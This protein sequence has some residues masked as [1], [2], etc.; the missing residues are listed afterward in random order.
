MEKLTKRQLEAA[1]ILHGALSGD[2]KDTER[3][4]E[5][6]STSDL[7]VQLTPALQRIAL[8]NY[9]EQPKQWGKYATRVIHDDFRV[10]EYN[11]FQF[12]QE[13]IEPNNAG[14][15][16][17]EG[18]LPTVAE[19]DSYPVI[20]FSATEESLRLKKSGEQIQFSWES[21]VNDRN[22][23]ILEE[24]PAAFGR[25]AAGKEELE[26]VK[27]LISP[28]G[29]NAANF[30]AGNGNVLAGNPALTLE[31]LQAAFAQI[32]TQTYNG[33]RAT[34]P[35]RYIL[36]VPPALEAAANAIKNLSEIRV[37]VTDGDTETVTV[38]GNTV[39]SKFEVVVQDWL[40]RVNPGADNYWFL[41][42][43][44]GSTPNPS[45]TMSFLRGHESPEIWVKS[46]DAFY[47]GG[48]QVPARQGNFDNDSFQTRVRH[49]AT[50][51]FLLPQGTFGS[52]G[53]GS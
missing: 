37:I 46:S 43:V 50:G 49:T 44:L 40:T 9:T 10:K 35:S 28:T 27:P 16:F 5:G 17:Y 14:D 18:A 38:T 32:A 30:N 33:V 48:G 31:N 4:I 1:E 22:I 13:D 7:P 15:T 3:L 12:S 42:P 11:N 6:V 24:V 34:V 20:R 23:G 41:L 51:G 2:R 29:L 8:R 52:T 25:H 47:L 53:A 26:S 21:I 19:Y 39:A 45:T 36:L